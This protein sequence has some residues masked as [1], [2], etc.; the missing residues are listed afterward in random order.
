MYIIMLYEKW[1]NY[2]FFTS[3][4]VY[5]YLYKQRGIQF[6]WYGLV[7]FTCNFVFIYIF[8]HGTVADFLTFN[9][10]FYTHR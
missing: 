6:P 8:Y 4:R 9:S 3:I 10:F 7:P 2:Y 1:L 5:K